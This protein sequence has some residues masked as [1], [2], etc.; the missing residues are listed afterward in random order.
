M[1]IPQISEVFVKGF[2]HKFG[3]TL[4]KTKGFYKLREAATQ[5]QQSAFEQ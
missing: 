5:Q 1:I 3:I 4:R 2:H